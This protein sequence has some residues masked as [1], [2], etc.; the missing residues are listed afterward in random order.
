VD[1]TRPRLGSN[2]GVWNREPPG[3]VTSATLP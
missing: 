1:S 3:A 2:V